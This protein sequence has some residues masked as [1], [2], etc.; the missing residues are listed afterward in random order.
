MLYPEKLKNNL[1]YNPIVPYK[2][3][4]YVRK[5]TFIR[6][7]IVKVIPV[8]IISEFIFEN[9]EK[10]NKQGFYFNTQQ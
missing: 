3:D 7:G 5:H 9:K 10:L 6:Y 2:S 1:S 4:L 8:E